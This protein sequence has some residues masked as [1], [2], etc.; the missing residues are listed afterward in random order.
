MHQEYTVKIITCLTF[1]VVGHTY[2]FLGENSL[3]PAYLSVGERNILLTDE[4]SGCDF[5]VNSGAWGNKI[6]P[7]DNSSPVL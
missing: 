2:L 1:C 5:S 4:P 7:P 3:A 6:L